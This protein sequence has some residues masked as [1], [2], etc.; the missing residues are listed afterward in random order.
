M[1]RESA[2]TNQTRGVQVFIIYTQHSAIQN[3]S[4]D[5]NVKML[6]NRVTRWQNKPCK[7]QGNYTHDLDLRVN[8]IYCTSQ[9]MNPLLPTIHTLDIWQKGHAQLRRQICRLP[10][11][12]LCKK[13]NFR[14]EKQCSQQQKIMRM[15]P[16]L[17][18]HHGECRS[19]LVLFSPQCD[20]LRGRVQRGDI[21]CHSCGL[22]DVL[23][24]VATGTDHVAVLRLLHLH[25]HR[26]ALAPLREK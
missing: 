19:Q 25:R 10:C 6:N 26:L 22:Q 17:R 9:Q 13:N 3:S 24:T 23:D 5:P 4:K 14:S 20:G 18:V 16:Y 1:K 8:H 7:C 12:K 15:A 21:H 11:R 2:D